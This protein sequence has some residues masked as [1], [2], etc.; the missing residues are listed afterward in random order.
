MST[1]SFAQAL[2]RQ[3]RCCST[4]PHKEKQ[5]DTSRHMTEKQNINNQH[6]Q[7]H[8]QQSKLR[9]LA[10]R[11]NKAT[12]PSL[13]TK[14]QAVALLAAATAATPTGAATVPAGCDNPEAF[15]HENGK[16]YLVVTEKKGAVQANEFCA[17][18]GGALA[19]VNTKQQKQLMQKVGEHHLWVHETSKVCDSSSSDSSSSS[20]SSSSSGDSSKKGNIGKMVKQLIEQA[21]HN[22]DSKSVSSQS[23]GGSN[24]SH[25]SK[26]KSSREGRHLNSRVPF[27]KARGTPGHVKRTLRHRSSVKAPPTKCCVFEPPTIWNWWNGKF[28]DKKKKKCNAQN[29][30]ICEFQ[31]DEDIITTTTIAENIITIKEGW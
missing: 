26:K 16:S 27:N 23:S 8:K 20:S 14:L 30:F 4:T 25:N 19:G 6:H 21:S 13:Y 9:T 2:Q 28:N 15:T 17:S 24:H 12:M 1:F 31:C 29:Y 11:T 7:K 18:L 10:I 22:S 3:Q 5:K